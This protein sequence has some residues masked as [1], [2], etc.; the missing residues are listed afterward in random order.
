MLRLDKNPFGRQDLGPWRRLEASEGSRG[1]FLLEAP[2]DPGGLWRPLEGFGLRG[3]LEAPRGPWRPVKEPEK[4][5]S[6]G[7]CK[8][9][10][11]VK[12]WLKNVRKSIV[13]AGA[14]TLPS[15]AHSKHVGELTQTIS[16]PN[17][18][19]VP[20]P[21]LHVNVAEHAALSHPAKLTWK[22]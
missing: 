8:G 3:T 4:D 1:L 6:W 7:T 14:H 18:L 10:L 22:G 2:G 17:T 16:S 12:K 15:E 13:P 11:R 9:L 19:T 5:S 20:R 21:P